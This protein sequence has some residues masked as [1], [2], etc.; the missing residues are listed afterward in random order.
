MLSTLP[1]ELEPIAVRMPEASRMSGLS[2]TSL[3][4]LTKSGRLPIKKV[5][6]CT[7]IMVDDLR[8]LI[9]TE[10]A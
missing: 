10:A 8:R 9:E 1:E 6:G 2:R 3:Y 4:R 7:L 5:G